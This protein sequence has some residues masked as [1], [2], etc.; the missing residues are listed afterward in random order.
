MATTLNCAL[1]QPPELERLIHAEPAV[2]AQWRTLPRRHFAPGECLQAAGQP[3]THS[4][5]IEQGLVRCF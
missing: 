2:A 3:C 4:W 5:L 1:C